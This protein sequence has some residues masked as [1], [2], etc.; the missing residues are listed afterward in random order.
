MKYDSVY[1]VE[2][3]EFKLNAK[4]SRED[5]LKILNWKFFMNGQNIGG[6]KIKYN[7]C[8]IFVTY[9]KKE[10][11]SETI[12]Y[13]DEF[14]SRDVFSWMSR[15]N[16]KIDSNELKPLVNYTDIDIRLFVKK[17]DDEGIDFYY[18]G[19]L[20]PLGEPIQLYRTIDGRENPIVNFKFKIE[21]SVDEKLYNYFMDK[22]DEE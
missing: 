9:D 4:Y 14:E 3:D 16:R 17:S 7:T 13:E 5:V 20:S 1:R 12:N 8:P 19:K 18:I 10:D 15:N 21:H 22:L 11:I 2:D 6:Y